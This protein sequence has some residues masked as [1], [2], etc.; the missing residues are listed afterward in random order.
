MD[1][2]YGP[3]PFG[4]K[5]GGAGRNK[6]PFIVG[7]PTMS[8]SDGTKAKREKSTVIRQQRISLPVVGRRDK[9]GT[10]LQENGAIEKKVGGKIIREC[11][12]QL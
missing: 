1:S 8:V 12:R 5:E 2:S 4:I 6:T 10:A 7:Q 3:S 9:K 11:Q